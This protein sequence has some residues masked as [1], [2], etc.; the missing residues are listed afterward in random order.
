[1]KPVSDYWK[2]NNIE[3][4]DSYVVCAAMLKDGR[5]I[6]GARHFDKVMRDQMEASEGI[7]WWRGCEQGFINQF[8]EFLTRKEAWAIADKNGQIKLYD[9]AGSNKRIAQPANQATE[10][11]LFSENLY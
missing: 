3:K 4:P 6:T 11:I 1:M 8:G 2:D 10:G 9:P 5:I 7:A